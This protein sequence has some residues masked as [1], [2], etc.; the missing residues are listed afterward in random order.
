MLGW[1]DFV[2]SQLRG[3]P[4]TICQLSGPHK[5]FFKGFRPPTTVT[6]G[7]LLAVVFF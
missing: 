7:T 6:D 2:I 5:D 4:K 3:G 1:F